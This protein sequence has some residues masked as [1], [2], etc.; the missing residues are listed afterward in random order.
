MLDEGFL[1]G[2]AFYPSLAHEPHHI[3][4]ALEATNRAFQLLTT[5]IAEGTVRDRLRGPVAFAGLRGPR[6]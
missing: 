6:V 3:D 2:G 4:A 1:A 5:A